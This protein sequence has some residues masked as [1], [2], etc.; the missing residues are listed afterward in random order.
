MEEVP[1]PST[2][3][4]GGVIAK[5]AKP[6]LRSRLREQVNQAAAADDAGVGTLHCIELG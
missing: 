6:V 5:I 4:L 3:G 1:A 2:F